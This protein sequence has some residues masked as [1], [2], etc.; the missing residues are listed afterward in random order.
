MH[1]F[2]GKS[3][4][5]C[6]SYLR[7]QVMDWLHERT[8]LDKMT[9]TYANSLKINGLFFLKQLKSLSENVMCP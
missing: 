2:S 3:V 6:K 7:S 5:N 1:T 8:K 9:R 4:F